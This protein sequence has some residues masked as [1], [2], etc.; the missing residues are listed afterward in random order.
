MRGVVYV[1]SEDCELFDV[2]GSTGTGAAVVGGK[3]DADY[4][5]VCG[6]VWW[7]GKLPVREV[8]YW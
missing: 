4:G 8:D 5:V 2:V 3:F 7:E 6:F 1:S